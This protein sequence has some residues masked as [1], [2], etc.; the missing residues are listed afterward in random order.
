M[1]TAEAQKKWRDKHRF[2]KRQ[3]NVMTGKR[4]HQY[5]GEIADQFDTYVNVSGGGMTG[6]AGAIRLGLSRALI[7]LNPNLRAELKKAGFLTRDAR[8]VERK[9]YGQPGAR[10]RFQF[11]K[12]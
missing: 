8:V 3:L 5:L 9:K 2:V 1:A 7:Q 6:Q 10:K 11:S 4:V 12:R